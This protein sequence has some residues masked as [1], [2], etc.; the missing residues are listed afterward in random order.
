[1]NELFHSNYQT[2]KKADII[3]LEGEMSKTLTKLETSDKRELI[4][5]YEKIITFL[6]VKKNSLFFVEI[7]SK[8]VRRWRGGVLGYSEG[9]TSWKTGR[10]R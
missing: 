3:K 1:M 7:K 4:N 2:N 10:D 8:I 5:F 6:N 9:C